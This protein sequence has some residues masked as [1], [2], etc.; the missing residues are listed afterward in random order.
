MTDDSVPRK[1]EDQAKQWWMWLR[2]RWPSILVALFLLAVPTWVVIDHLYA[3]RLQNRQEEI[4]ALQREP[5]AARAQFRSEA[6]DPLSLGPIGGAAE[7]SDARG[8]SKPKSPPP[9]SAPTGV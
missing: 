6:K 8:P 7:G 3:V 2:D 9:S 5:A 4:A 1:L